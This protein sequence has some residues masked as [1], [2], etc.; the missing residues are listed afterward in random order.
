MALAVPLC[1][2]EPHIAHTRTHTQAY[3]GTIANLRQVLVEMNRTDAVS[4][5]DRA[6]AEDQREPTLARLASKGPSIK[7]APGLYCVS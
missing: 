1:K 2:P 4:V 7:T 5:I 3:D 6:L